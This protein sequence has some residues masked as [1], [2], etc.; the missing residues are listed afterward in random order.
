LQKVEDAIDD[1]LIA[2]INEFDI[3]QM[4][5]INRFIMTFIQPNPLLKVQSSLHS[6]F[7]PSHTIGRGHLLRVLT[8]VIGGGNFDVEDI[9]HDQLFVA[10]DTLDKHEVNAYLLTLVCDPLASLPSGI[11]GIEHGDHTVLLAEPFEDIVEGLLGSEFAET[12]ALGIVGVKERGRWVLVA[13]C[14]AILADVEGL[15][16]DAEPC[17]VLAHCTHGQHLS[18]GLLLAGP[19]E[20]IK[21]TD[22]SGQ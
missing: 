4:R 17:Q 16:G 3:R 14:S 7:P 21:G 22:L 15:C 5:F 13:C 10:A 2:D 6:A 12:G 1:D 11:G 19:A 20:G 18:P 9:A 8:D